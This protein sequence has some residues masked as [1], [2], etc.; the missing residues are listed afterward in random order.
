MTEQEANQG[1]PYAV[2]TSTITIDG[3]TYVTD[4]ITGEII[5][6]ASVADGDRTVG[7][8]EFHVSDEDSA[9][10]V[11]DK[12]RGADAELVGIDAAMRA[13]IEAVER[14]WRSKARRIGAKIAWLRGRFEGEVIEW[15][16]PQI[17]GKAKSIKVGAGLCGTR[18]TRASAEIVDMPQLVMHAVMKMPEVVHVKTFELPKDASVV[19]VAVNVLGKLRDAGCIV[20]LKV[21]PSD[22]VK[23]VV[24]RTEPDQDPET[25]EII[26][27]TLYSLPPGITY[28]PARDVAYLKS[29]VKVPK[30]AEKLIGA[31]SD[32]EEE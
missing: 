30:S 13:E 11:V 19:P 15:A 12:L 29:G 6:I 3:W 2:A 16:L 9:K 25:G 27:K 32:E 1:D 7:H 26:Q 8:E 5:D 4:A 23:M 24:E 20:D 18:T 10:W 22:A 21:N 14:S 31:G 17:T 28:T